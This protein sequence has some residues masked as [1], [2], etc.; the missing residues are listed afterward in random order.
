MFY[1]VSSNFD[2][3]GTRIFVPFVNQNP[4]VFEGLALQTQS[5]AVF[6]EGRAPKSQTAFNF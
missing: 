1:K 4:S 3:F 5:R 6:A 2:G